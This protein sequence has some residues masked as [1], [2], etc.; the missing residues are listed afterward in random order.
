MTHNGYEM[1]PHEGSRSDTQST[2][3]FSDGEHKARL[4]AKHVEQN[5]LGNDNTGHI[6]SNGAQSQRSPPQPLRMLPFRPNLD[7]ESTRLLFLPSDPETFDLRHADAKDDQSPAGDWIDLRCEG[8]EDESVEV[9]RVLAVAQSLYS[10]ACHISIRGSSGAVPLTFEIYFDPSS[11]GVSLYNTYHSTMILS[12]REQSDDSQIRVYSRTTAQLSPGEWELVAPECSCTTKLLVLTRRF[13]PP[14][15]QA[16]SSHVLD[17]KRSAPP[18][19][20]EPSQSS[21]PMLSLLKFRTR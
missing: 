11:D 7:G 16:E 21:G 2:Q 13:L 17:Q 19:T 6:L 20:A 5:L 3:P 9:L 18:T 12:T 10:V 8:D 4:Q 14:S 1:D 15:G